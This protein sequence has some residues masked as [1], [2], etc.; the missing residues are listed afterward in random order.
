MLKKL[1]GLNQYTAGTIEWAQGPEGKAFLRSAH[2]RWRFAFALSCLLTAPPPST[3]PLQNAGLRPVLMHIS[4]HG[5]AGFMGA[6]APASSG[7]NGAS[8]QLVEMAGGG[9][10]LE[11]L[12]INALMQAFCHTSGVTP[13]DYVDCIDFWDICPVKLHIPYTLKGGKQ[14]A[15]MSPALALLDSMPHTRGIFPAYMRAVNAALKSKLDGRGSY[16]VCNWGDESE[17]GIEFFKSLRM[18]DVPYFTRLVH[19][20]NGALAKIPHPQ[21]LAVLYCQ[22]S[23]IVAARRADTSLSRIAHLLPSCM[24]DCSAYAM[25]FGKT[26]AEQDFISKLRTAACKAAGALGGALAGAVRSPPSPA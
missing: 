14:L 15:P 17:R 23:D 21:V 7:R 11:N 5:R 9:V 19:S 18:Q 4:L 26:P 20:T 10:G 6:Y 12:S 1:T 8:F 2:V 24:H 25:S 16:L 13:R 3:A 22:L